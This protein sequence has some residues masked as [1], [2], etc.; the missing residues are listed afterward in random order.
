MTFNNRST[1]ISLA[2]G[3]LLAFSFNCAQGADETPPKTIKKLPYTAAELLDLKGRYTYEGEKLGLV[4]FP[5]GGIGSGSISLDGRGALVDWQIQNRPNVDYQPDHT[6]LGLWAKAEGEK[7]LF[8][9]LEGPVPPH[10]AGNTRI[11]GFPAATVLEGWPN[12]VKG[13]R[14][15]A[16]LFFMGS[17]LSVW[18]N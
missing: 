13:C 2:T 4:R 12:G 14:T 17:F 11:S 10:Y 15:F 3:M 1:I 16:R 18:S 6:F 5:L 7:P 8:R 9:V